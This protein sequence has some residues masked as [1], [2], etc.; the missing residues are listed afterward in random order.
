MIQPAQNMR[1]VVSESAD[2]LLCVNRCCAA[3]PLEAQNTPAVITIKRENKCIPAPK[4]APLP[5][6]DI[7]AAGS[8]YSDNQ[9][10]KNAVR[11]EKI[12]F[13]A[14]LE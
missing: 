2:M 5:G 14:Y 12:R 7:H 10:S 4:K 13:T 8:S 1:K 9:S 3:S 11:R 6:S